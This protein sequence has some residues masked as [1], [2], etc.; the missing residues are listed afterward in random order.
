MAINND[1]ASVNSGS[2]L[3]N[4]IS[5]QTVVSQDLSS[6]VSQL[7]TQASDQSKMF[8]QMM[9]KQEKWDQRAACA[10]KK[11]VAATQ[12]FNEKLL[13]MMMSMMN[14][15]RKSKQSRKQKKKPVT[16]TRLTLQERPAP[17]PMWQAAM[18]R[19]N[20]RAKHEN[21]KDKDTEDNEDRDITL[22]DEDLGSAAPSH[23]G[24]NGEIGPFLDDEDEEDNG[25]YDG[26]DFGDDDGSD[27]DG[28]NSDNEDGSSRS[29]GNVS[30]GSLGSDS[31]DSSTTKGAGNRPIAKNNS[32]AQK[33]V[34][35]ISAP[36][37]APPPVTGT[38]DAITH[39]DSTRKSL[40]EATRRVPTRARKPLGKSN[41]SKAE[42]LAHLAD[43]ISAKQQE[44][45]DCAKRKRLLGI[46]TDLTFDSAST[47]A[48]PML[49]TPPKS[50]SRQ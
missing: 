13:N 12:R 44:L 30:S 25:Y 46:P 18:D 39:E 17:S 5:G 21:D 37:K 4:G 45:A 41:M 14:D 26:D 36:S 3:A 49:T 43:K 1:N 50:R 32:K 22:A 28:D 20:K 35:D 48:D 47:D 16:P 9:D 23:Y 38:V 7:Q 34:Q 40:G 31:D 11:A 8:Q 10:Q 33:T 27:K 24:D 42:A 15:N 19:S 2:T 6:I 29:S